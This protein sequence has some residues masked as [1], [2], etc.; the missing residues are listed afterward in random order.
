MINGFCIGAGM[1]IA[2]RAHIRIAAE[3]ST[4]A[5]PAARLGL[6]YVFDATRRLVDLVGPA[7]A[8]DIM[9]SAHKPGTDEV[10][11][12]GLINQIV[13]AGELEEATRKYAALLLANAPLSMQASK[14]SIGGA[15]KDPAERDLEAMEA[16]IWGCYDTEAVMPR[17][18]GT[19]HQLRH[20]IGAGDTL[21]AANP[22][23]KIPVGVAP[24]AANLYGETVRP[25]SGDA[26]VLRPAD[27]GRNRLAHRSA[28]SAR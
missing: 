27:G 15:L 20:G 1:A 2:T 10:L 26:G 5:I 11:R 18:D 28:H 13:P 4:F 24:D 17:T 8:T 7:F 3:G 25:D 12:I 19:G 21:P 16:A 23:Q 22:A 9:F 14:L 6:A